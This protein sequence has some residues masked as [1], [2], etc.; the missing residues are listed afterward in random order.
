MRTRYLRLHTLRT[1]LKK[2]GNEFRRI[3]KLG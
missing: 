2:K 1:R 3:K